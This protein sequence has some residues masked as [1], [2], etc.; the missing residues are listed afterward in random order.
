LKELHLTEGRNT[1]FQKIIRVLRANGSP[2]PLF[3]TDEERT[4]FLAT[5]FIHSS[6]TLSNDNVNGD[7]RGDTKGAKH[8]A[9]VLAAI[10]ENPHITIAALAQT[11][12]VSQS[13]VSRVLKK[14]KDEK[15]IQREG[16][17]KRGKWIVL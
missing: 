9:R 6:F 14:L 8:E 7:E 13:T 5:L 1:G 10:R 3:E 4:F 16:A 15:I 17:D 11:M 2:M 12:G